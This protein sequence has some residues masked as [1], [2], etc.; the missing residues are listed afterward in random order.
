MPGRRHSGGR[1]RQAPREHVPARQHRARQRARHVRPRA[2]HRHL[3]GDRRG[4]DQ[5]VRL[6]ARSRPGP[7]VG[8]HCLPIDP[9][10]LS[11]QVQRAP[12]P[13]AAASS[14][15]PTTSTTTCPTTWC[16]GIG[17]RAQPSC[18][19]RSTAPGCCCSGWPT[20]RT[21]ATPAS[22]R[23]PV[24]PS[25]CVD[26]GADVR[27]ADP[28]VDV[29]ACT[30]P[31]HPGGGRPTRRSRPLTLVIV[32]TDHDA[33][34][35]IRIAARRRTCSTRATASPE[36]TLP[37][38][39]PA[40]A[41]HG[42]SGTLTVMCVAGARPNFMKVKP[43]IARAG[44]ARCR[45]VLV[46]TG[47]HYDDGDERRV[48]RRARHPAAGPPPRGRL[49]QPRRADRG[50][51]D[52]RSSRWSRPSGPTS[53]VVVGDVNSTAGLRAGRGQGRVPRRP[54]RGGAP[55]P[56]L[57]DAR[58]GQPGRHRPAERLAVRTVGRRRREP[59]GRGLPRRP[60]PPRRQ[61]HGRHAAR[62]PRPGARTRDAMPARAL[63]LGPGGY[64]LVTLHR[65]SNVDDRPSARRAHR[66]R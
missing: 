13:H 4:V 29:A 31:G 32:L 44:V 10:Y 35:W 47:Q 60:D 49:G 18:S 12:R 48:L 37:T 46:H 42:V 15:W 11:W 27:A 62:Q 21:P 65:P 66:T 14:T 55:Q 9:R 2:G 54:R 24:S 1:A 52:W 40:G 22:L 25:C 28:I 36:H 57:G 7:G 3:E 39:D 5:A 19:S 45:T 20:R 63:G 61:R 8:G 38:S 43:V 34:D 59:A 6:H 16:A 30:V 17:R 41:M 50:D 23:R 51:D 26:L 53:V 33:F 56:R 64:G 58:R